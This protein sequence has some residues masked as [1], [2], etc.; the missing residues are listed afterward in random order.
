M[1]MAVE[2][3]VPVLMNMRER[4][5]FFYSV[6]DMA[7]AMRIVLM[8]FICCFI[9]IVGVPMRGIHIMV[10]MSLLHFL[11]MVVCG[12]AVIVMVVVVIFPALIMAARGII[13]RML[14]AVKVTALF[15]IL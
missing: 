15:Y 10:V 12:G 1:V 9:M 6:M 13:V 2:K 11:L 14:V 4:A 7:V 8:I 3:I 5:I